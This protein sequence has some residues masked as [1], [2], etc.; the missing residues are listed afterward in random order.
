MINDNFQ[1]KPSISFQLQGIS[2]GY[3]KREH[4]ENIIRRCN[5]PVSKGIYAYTS[6]NIHNYDISSNSDK[7]RNIKIK[8]Y[9]KMLIRT[10]MPLSTS[11]RFDFW[12]ITNVLM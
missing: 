3:P 2:R 1:R 6:A 5:S 12:H 10:K 4:F 11:N 9:C 7:K 8:M